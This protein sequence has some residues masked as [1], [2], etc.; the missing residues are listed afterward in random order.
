MKRMLIV[1]TWAFSAC[2]MC[3]AGTIKIDGKG[4]VRRAP[5][6]VVITFEISALHTNMVESLRLLSAQE[7]QIVNVLM[8][9]GIR[10]NELQTSVASM[11][12]QYHDEDENGAILH[13]IC[14]TDKIV[15]QVFDGY[16]HSM[17]FKLRFPLAQERIER[18]YIAIIS[19][20][21][22]KDLD[23]RLCLLN[24]ESAREQARMLAVKNAKAIAESLCRAA[25]SR[26]VSVLEIDYGES[27]RCVEDMVAYADV[28]PIRP[29]SRG[30][31]SMPKLPPIRAED[32]EVKESVHVIWSIEDWLGGRR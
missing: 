26:I 30:E 16:R 27:T 15:K 21:Y 5:D 29:V 19:R 32:I 12:P 22:V 24:Q 10:T 23:I 14:N 2:G 25:S 31:V 13:G 8:Q 20:Q 18:A 7:S 9:A 6:G 4:I 17:K 11:S 3:F 28:A 1:V